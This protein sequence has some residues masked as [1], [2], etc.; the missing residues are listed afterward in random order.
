MKGSAL[1]VTASFALGLTG[2]CALFRPDRAALAASGLVSQTLCSAKFVSG[3]DPDRVYAETVRPM[4]GMR[5]IDWAIKYHVDPQRREVTTTVAGLCRSRAA[6][7]DGLGCL[8][9][10]GAMPPA[11]TIA[12]SHAVVPAAPAIVGPSNDRIRAALDRIFAR[13]DLG[14]SAV[15]VMHEGRIIAERYADGYDTSTPLRGWSVAK[16]ILNALIGVLVRDGRLRIDQAAAVS[17]WSAPDDPRRAITMD[18]LLRMTSG[19]AIEETGSGFDP[20]SRMLLVE[21]DMAGFAEKARLEAEPGS[22][23]RY[24]S[25]NTMILSRIIRDAVGGRAED[26]V[27][28]ARRELLDP[29]GMSNVTI[30]F[31]ATGTPS[32]SVYASARDWARFGQLYADDGVADGRR[33]LPAGWVKYST[34]PTLRSGYGA[35][36]WLGGPAWRT[37]WH[38]PGDAFYASGH[39]HQKILI[40]P[41]R[42]LVIAR[43]GVTHAPDDGFGYLAEEVLGALQE[44][45]RDRASP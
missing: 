9:V 8:L 29:L 28:F 10:H 32:G 14:T 36:F 5:F 17:A 43:F 19:L 11:S 26:V 44:S 13:H 40:V 38:V 25:G 39:L 6:Y 30:E 27:R 31:D 22:R 23:W 20:V 12:T 37:D 45:E 1:V 4:S 16:S 42:R 35:G 3:L 41:S 7:R 34:K 33:I 21:W 15:V 2:A 18:H 24:T